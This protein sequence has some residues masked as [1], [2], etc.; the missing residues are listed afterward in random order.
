MKYVKLIAKANEDGPHW[1]KPGTEVL[2]YDEVRRISAAEWEQCLLD[3]FV[4]GRGIRICESHSEL[5]E[6][7][8][9]YE[10]G[11]CCLIDEFEVEFVNEISPHDPAAGI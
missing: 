5:H 3:G 10:D 8:D 7:G 9:E 2:H 1:F 4:L 11:E 6:I